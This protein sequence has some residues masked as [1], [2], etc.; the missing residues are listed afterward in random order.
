M[1]DN[2]IY[3]YEI[4]YALYK[5]DFIELNNIIKSLCKKDIHADIN[6]GYHVRSLYFDDY[7]DNAYVDKEASV[8]G[9]YKFRIR[10]YNIDNNLIKLEKKIKKG[11]LCAKQS[12]IITPNDYD[13][14]MAKNY[15]SL[16]SYDGEMVKKFYTECQNNILTPKIIID[17]K[18]EAY[19]Y[20][21]GNDYIRL[22]FDSDIAWA[23]NSLDIFDDKICLHNL[24]NT[25][26]NVFELKC[27]SLVPELLMDIIHPIANYKTSFSKYQLC[28][29]EKENLL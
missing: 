18:R 9:R 4:K 29:M 15:N 24:N 2:L 6:G 17:Y 27:S 3:R 13:N 21:F 10:T 22:T 5:S 12:T 1:A 20:K 28:R 25:M 8:Q 19:V 16:L 11:K 23:T 26:A 14:V 7:Y